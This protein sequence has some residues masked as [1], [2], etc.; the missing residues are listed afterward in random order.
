MI[1]YNSIFH[2]KKII[3]TGHP[4]QSQYRLHAV[5]QT[6]QNICIQSVPNHADSCSI[7]TVLVHDIV[8]HQRRGLT[9]NNRL[10]ASAASYCPHHRAVSG[11]LLLVCEVHHGVRVRSDKQTALVQTEA[12]LGVLDLVV[13]DVGIET[14]NN[15]ADVRVVLHP[16][17]GRRVHPFVCIGR[18]ACVRNSEQVQL[19]ANAVLSNDVRLLPRR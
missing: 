9:Y 15:C 13:I 19:L 5:V 16:T 2:S 1:R 3:L 11:P 18:P 4:R 8:N 12:Q 17:A 10:S 7:E 14:Y 6:K